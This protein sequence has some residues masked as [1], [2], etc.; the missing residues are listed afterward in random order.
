VRANLS[1]TVEEFAVAAA[2]ISHGT[3]H[4]ILSE[5]L[6]KSRVAQPNVPRI[7]TQGQRDDRKSTCGYLIY[8][9]D[10]DGKLLNR[11]VAGVETWC[12][13]YDP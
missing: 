6:N 1:Q 5:K 11:I 9:S 12:F 4:N 8:S 2:G 7:L 3:C 13:L 10:K